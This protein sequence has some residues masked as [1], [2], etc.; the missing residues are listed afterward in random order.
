MILPFLTHD[1]SD[2]ACVIFYALYVY[3]P[4]KMKY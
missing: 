3:D 1:Q 2:L 4:N